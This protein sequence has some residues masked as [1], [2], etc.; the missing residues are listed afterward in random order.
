MNVN[1]IF[2]KVSTMKDVM[3]QLEMSSES[4]EGHD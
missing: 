1:Y 2:Q 3:D 4:S